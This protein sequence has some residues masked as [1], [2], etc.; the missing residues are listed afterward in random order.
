MGSSSNSGLAWTS[1]EDTRLVTIAAHVD[2]GKTT[3]ADQLL[4]HN[5]IISER[6]AG[7]LRYLDSDP[8][9]QRRGITMR[10]SAVGL[11]Y[12]YTAAKK[13]K[14]G[15]ASRPMIVHLVDSPGHT[16]FLRE[17]SSSMVA[18]DSAILLLDAVEGLTARTNQVFRETA[19]NQL[20]PVLVINKVDRY[21]TD[22]HLTATDAYLRLRSLLEI[23][24]AATAAMVASMHAD[25]ESGGDTETARQQ[26]EE[27]WT[28][29]PAVGNVVFASAI[30]GWG[31]TVPGLARHLFRSQQ[32][33]VKPPL[34][35]QYLFG[36]VRYTPEGK[37]VKWKQQNG[38]TVPV[39]AQVA[40]QPLWD[41]YEGLETAAAS[42]SSSS[43]LQIDTPGMQQVQHV[44]AAQSSLDLADILQ[45]SASADDCLRSILRRYRPLGDA[46]LHTV[47]EYCP[48]PTT[49]AQGSELQSAV[50]N[51]NSSDTTSTIAHV[52]KFFLTTRSNIRD[53]DLPGVGDGDGKVVLGLARVLSGTVHSGN[54]YHVLG[55]DAEQQQQ[56]SIRLYLLMGS[57]FL[58]VDRVPAGHLCAV[59]GLESM[60]MPTL[61]LASHPSCPPPLRVAD[62][63][64]QSHH[65]RPLVKVHVEAAQ[66]TDAAILERGLE[67][68][69]LVDGAVEVTITDKGELLL[70]CLG[71]LHLEQTILD[72]QH[73]YCDQEIE[74]RISDPIVDFAETTVWFTDPP[75]S[76]HTPESAP[77]LRQSTI[78]PY[79]EEEGIR[80]AHYGRCRAV[81]PG[82]GAAL[83]IRVLPLSP[84]VFEALQ[85]TSA[86]DGQDDT[87]EELL[88]LGRA[89][90]I[91][92]AND[93]DCVLQS[94]DRLSQCCEK[95]SGSMMMLSAGLAAGMF[96][97]GVEAD[98]VFMPKG[99]QDPSDYFDE[100]GSPGYDEFSSLRELRFK[101]FVDN[102]HDG[103]APAKD[104]AALHLWDS[105]IRGSVTAGFE[106][107]LRAGPVCEEPIRGILVVVESVEIAVKQSSEEDNFQPSKPLA[108]GMVVSAMRSGIRCAL[109]SRPVRLVEAYLRLTLHTPLTGL[110]SL[111]QVLNQRRGRVLEDAMLDG[112]D[113]LLITTLVPQAEAF[114]LAPDLLRKT[115]GE[116]SAPEMLFSHW[117]R[118]DVDPFWVP[119]SNEEREDFG[120]LQNV[121]DSST[122]VDNTAISYIR[123]VRRRK[124][125]PVDSSR[126][127]AN[128]EKQRTLKR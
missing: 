43:R 45:K 115:S 126:T 111:Y 124:G 36:D 91:E 94:I 19:R 71:E 97:R 25:T 128:A 16:D 8:E 92:P 83:Q 75:E 76:T 57:S 122:G 109:L 31:F 54:A 73:T 64:A 53:T 33:P 105:A 34:L 101:G 88:K 22:L 121:G 42:V 1:P 15:A 78:S 20:V 114:G 74:L 112:T 11:R 62:A 110:G 90:G 21:F 60:R 117:E 70:A 10:S 85:Q 119:T 49:P 127:V 14:D 102:D 59:Y 55:T 65:H 17:V 67:Q 58:H 41:I 18:C 104:V 24:N 72:L 103:E 23:V 39:F 106:T 9:E 26:Q 82:R 32:I 86:H 56:L 66:S 29:D 77:R 113:L 7:T 37:W 51:C 116:V 12:Q 46:L 6:A 84:G 48:S 80:L 98:E 120:E 100:S 5:G 96:T 69:R 89:L 13:Q 2:A 44:V 93:A 63:S 3:L 107:A 123:F 4:E 50:A 61:T 28:F 79:R 108:G 27:Q 35:R 118:L 87:H 125:L 38:D 81:L 40:L 99:K 47:C 52:C 95:Q 68:L 30:H